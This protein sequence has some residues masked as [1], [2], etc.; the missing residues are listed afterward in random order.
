M[1]VRS[2]QLK[3]P[4]GNLSADDYIV[5]SGAWSGELLAATGLQLPVEPVRGQM[6]LFN[7][8][9]GLVRTITLYK[10]AT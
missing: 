2:A 7:G 4:T 1:A 3:P 10:S 6:L 9:P 8:P 5:A